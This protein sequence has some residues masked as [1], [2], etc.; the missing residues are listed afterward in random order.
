[1]T[2]PQIHQLRLQLKST[3]YI[4]SILGLRNKIVT[5][6]FEIQTFQLTIDNEL[7]N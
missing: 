6:Y 1:M 2:H 3:K 7:L 5:E 4:K